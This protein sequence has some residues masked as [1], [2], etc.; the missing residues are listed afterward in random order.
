MSAK[1]NG[2]MLTVSE[3]SLA[4]G[5]YPRLTQFARVISPCS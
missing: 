3:S 1:K 5:D 4:P 2:V